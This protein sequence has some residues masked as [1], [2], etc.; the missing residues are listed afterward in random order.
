MSM[1]E[2][3]REYEAPLLDWDSS[4]DAD[5]FREIDQVECYECGRSIVVHVDSPDLAESGFYCPSCKKGK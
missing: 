1:Y 4:C 5:E 3:D 2:D